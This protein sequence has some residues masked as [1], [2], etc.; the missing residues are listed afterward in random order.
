LIIIPYLSN[1]DLG[2]VTLCQYEIPV[3]NNLGGIP[4][5]LISGGA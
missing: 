5:L 3:S 2:L 4:N 1:T